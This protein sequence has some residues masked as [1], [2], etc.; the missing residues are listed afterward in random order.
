MRRKKLAHPLLLLLC[1][2]L[3]G[4]GGCQ[5]IKKYA[6]IPREKG[7]ST[8]YRQALGKWTKTGSIYSA[9]ETR[10]LIHST[11]QSEEFRK[12]YAQEYARVYD[13]D[14]PQA[15]NISRDK[16][17][18]GN[19]TKA[20]SPREF[21]FYAYTPVAGANDFDKAQSSW[22]IYL[23]LGKE[24]LTPL[25]IKLIEPITPSW[26]IFFPYI[27]SCYGKFYSVKFPNSNNIE[28]ST[29]PLEL[30]FVGPLG[31]LTLVW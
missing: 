15:T 17:R 30:V 11:Y 1:L 25:E 8:T 28:A 2:L 9:F 31:R 20:A 24:S 7:I 21:F 13:L 23:L 6:Q 10:A 5:E 16:A 12:A 29:T 14:L 3:L 26:E 19:Q 4:N 27:Q 22:R 18:G